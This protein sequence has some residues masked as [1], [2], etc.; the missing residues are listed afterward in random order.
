M[1]TNASNRVPAGDSN[2]AAKWAWVSWGLKLKLFGLGLLTLLLAVITGMTVIAPTMFV[3][4]GVHYSL[5]GIF[6]A[7]LALDFA[8][9]LLCLTSPTARPTR[10]AVAGSVGCQFGAVIC[11]VT[12]LAAIP[13]LPVGVR[14]VAGF[15]LAACAQ[16]PA[17]VLFM[18]YIR[19]ISDIFGRTDLAQSPW[20]TLF[21]FGL[22]GGSVTTGIVA[23]AIV[24]ALVLFCPCLWWLGYSWLLAMEQGWR[25][26]HM[27]E[28]LFWPAIRLPPTLLAGLLVASAFSRYGRLLWQ[29]AQEIDRRRG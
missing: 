7:A 29:V 16:V 22:A 9:R 2:A 19:R 11:L 20:Q 23:L 26:I 13:E 27:P 15:L 8:G 6:G 12:P 1:T 5:A 4:P 18:A 14:V 24:L 25:N 3:M 17:A 21:F 28:A 10:L